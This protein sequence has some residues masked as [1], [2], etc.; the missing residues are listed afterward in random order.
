MG[1]IILSSR[2]GYTLVEV[3]ISMVVLGIALVSV[4]MVFAQSTFMMVDIRQKAVAAECVQDE[5]EAIR[6][7]S[8][9]DILLLNGTAFVAPAPPGIARFKNPVGAI[10]VDNP[11]GLNNIRRVT[12]T[13]GWTSSSGAAMS[14]SLATLVTKS[15][16]DK[17]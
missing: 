5:I 14:R 2:K 16:I 1:M 7:M 4:A 9:A 10:T 12:V 3:L 17:Q 13:V 15:G 11:L 6:S 8:Y